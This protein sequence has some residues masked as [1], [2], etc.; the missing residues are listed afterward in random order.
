MLA[1]SK[2]LELP[3]RVVV[4]YL[5]FCLFPLVWMTVQIVQ[6]SSSVIAAQQEAELL[7]FLGQ[8][9]SEVT[10]ELALEKTQDLQ[11]IVERYRRQK[12]LQYSAITTQ[13]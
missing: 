1:R 5:L 2:H 8:A 10:R 6:V 7:A 11:K 3:R 4:Y 12:S 9:A 13:D